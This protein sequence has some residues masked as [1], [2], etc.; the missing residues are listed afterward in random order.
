MATLNIN[1]SEFE[2][3]ILTFLLD[4]VMNSEQIESDILKKFVK[5]NGSKIRTQLTKAYLDSD[6]ENRFKYKRI[7]GVFDGSD[8]SIQ[9]IR[10]TPDKVGEIENKKD[11]MIKKI[12]KKVLKKE[13]LSIND[14]NMIK[15]ELNK[16][17]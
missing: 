2:V 16:G 8:K 12:L 14:I 4:A 5:E 9:Q 3:L 10:I 1:I 15:E 6:S 17:E 13:E 11:G 7:R